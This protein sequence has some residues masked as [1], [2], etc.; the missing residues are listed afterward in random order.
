MHTESVEGAVRSSIDF[1]T[2]IP[3]WSSMDSRQKFRAIAAYQK[4]PKPRKRREPKP[5]PEPFTPPPGYYS[6]AEL[7]E[8]HNRSYASLKRYVALGN[9]REYRVGHRV[10]YCEYDVILEIERCER[11]RRENGRRTG[12]KNKA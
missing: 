11:V 2:N 3:G 10:A 8:R 5:K 6:S 12:N 7:C 1:A 9:V 4:R